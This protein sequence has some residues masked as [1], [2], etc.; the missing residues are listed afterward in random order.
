MAAD[1]RSV[2]RTYGF[3]VCDPDGDCGPGTARLDYYADSPLEVHMTLAAD[4]S[5]IWVVSRELMAAALRCPAPL[6]IGDVMFQSVR[7]HFNMQLRGFDED[8][9]HMGVFSLQ[10]SRRAIVEFV[11]LTERIFPVGEEVLD[12]DSDLAVLLRG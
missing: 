3:R 2:R 10:F 12:I 11:A 7:G 8:G 5:A 6:G 9:I 4:N 1:T